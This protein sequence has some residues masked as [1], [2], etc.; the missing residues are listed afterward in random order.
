MPFATQPAEI[1]FH[2]EELRSERRVVRGIGGDCEVAAGQALAVLFDVQGHGVCVDGLLCRAPEG[3]LSASNF[4][5]AMLLNEQ[6]SSRLA[7]SKKKK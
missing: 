1:A 5:G 2:G 3:A 7:V 6:T 4:D